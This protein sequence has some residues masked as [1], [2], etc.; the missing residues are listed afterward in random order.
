MSE[1]LSPRHSPPRPRDDVSPSA[2][3]PPYVVASFPTL[4]E[5]SAPFL[6]SRQRIVVHRTVKPHPRVSKTL[7]PR[8]GVE[9]TYRRPLNTLSTRGSPSDVGWD[10]LQLRTCFIYSLHRPNVST[11]AN[12]SLRRGPPGTPFSFL[13]DVAGF[14]VRSLPCVVASLPPLQ[15]SP[16]CIDVRQTRLGRCGCS[17][18]SGCVVAL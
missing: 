14:V 12:L 9:M 6:A 1:T 10:G 7:P 15:G 5:R 13:V 3:R 11:S 16:R 4:S 8:H 2:Q 18:T 17:A